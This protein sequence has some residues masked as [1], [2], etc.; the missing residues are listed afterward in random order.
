MKHFTSHLALLAIVALAPLVL[1]CNKDKIAPKG[2]EHAEGT[3]AIELR[4]NAQLTLQEKAD[5]ALA[6]S[7]KLDQPFDVFDPS[8]TI[9]ADGRIERFPEAGLRMYT[10]QFQSPP[11]AGSPCG[12]KPA[13]VALALTRRLENARVSGALTVY[14]EAKPVKVLRL[15]GELPIR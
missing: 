10:A 4:A 3:I 15:A 6:V 7:M 12:D 9:V 13:S 2:P 8:A 5:D 14:C 11:R 1:A